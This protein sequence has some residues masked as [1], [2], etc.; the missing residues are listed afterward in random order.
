MKWL[1]EVLGA[2]AAL[3]LVAQQALTYLFPLPPRKFV[4]PKL[5]NALTVLFLPTTA[6]GLIAFGEGSALQRTGELV[7]NPAILPPTQSVPKADDYD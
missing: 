2:V 4:Y 6:Y 7:A 1:P 3:L 5:Q